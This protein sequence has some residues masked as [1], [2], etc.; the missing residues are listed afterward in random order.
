M[1]LFV[2]NEKG[3][4]IEGRSFDYD[5]RDAGDRSRKLGF[6]GQ[7]GERATSCWCGFE[8]PLQLRARSSVKAARREALRQCAWV[9]ALRAP[10]RIL[11]RNHD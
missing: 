7:S 5:S 3:R 2:S 1:G 8:R 10:T 9:A 4:G 6:L 11:G